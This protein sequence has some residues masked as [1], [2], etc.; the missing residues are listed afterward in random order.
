MAEKVRIT[1]DEFGSKNRD[2]V[3]CYHTVAHK[4]NG[5]VPAIDNVTTWHLRDLSLGVKQMIKG[6][7]AKQ[8]HV[9]QYEQL[10]VDD[11]LKYIE[12][13]PFVKMCLPDR[14]KEIRKMGR[15]YLINVIYTRVGEKFK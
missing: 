3:E 9:P 13:Y 2:K 10:T 7:E 11:L 15:Q 4:F 6:P 5:Y 12:D 14:E 1:A 8:L